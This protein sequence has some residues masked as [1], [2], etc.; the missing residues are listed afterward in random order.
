[1]FFEHPRNGKEIKD[2]Y[3]FGSGIDLIKYVTK[4]HKVESIISFLFNILILY[5]TLNIQ[6]HRYHLPPQDH[7]HG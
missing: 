3:H 7:L 6:G 1:M 2:F 4:L 5:R